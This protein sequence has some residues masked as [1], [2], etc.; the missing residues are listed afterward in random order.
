MF[1]IA[2]GLL[3]FAFLASLGAAVSPA[4]LGVG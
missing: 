4:L 1:Y 3:N 2:L